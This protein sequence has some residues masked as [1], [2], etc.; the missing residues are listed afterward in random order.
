M[1]TPATIT[2]AGLSDTEDDYGNKVASPT[3]RSVCIAWF[4]A[5][6]SES[7]SLEDRQTIRRDVYLPPCLS[8]TGSDQITFDGYEWQFDGAPQDWVDPHTRVAEYAQGVVWR[9][10]G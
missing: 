6:A 10:T 2:A 7:G 4:P 3:T 5:G 1:N 9:T 8:L